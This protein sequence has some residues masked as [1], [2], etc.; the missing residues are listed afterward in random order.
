MYFLYKPVQT[1]FGLRL[2]TPNLVPRTVRLGL[3][4]RNGL[5][6]GKCSKP[7]DV[8]MIQEYIVSFISEDAAK[9]ML[10]EVGDDNQFIIRRHKKSYKVSEE[11]AKHYLK[12][13]GN[14]LTK[15]Q[16]RTS[17][18]YEVGDL[19][20]L[21]AD[22]AKRIDLLERLLLRLSYYILRGEEIPEEI[23]HSYLPLI[24]QYIQDVDSGEI[25]TR[26]DIEDI[27]EIFSKLKD[28]MSKIT[29]IVEKDYL[30]KKDKDLDVALPVPKTIV[31][32]P[33]QKQD[34]EENTEESK[35]SRIKQQKE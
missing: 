22:Q 19:Y 2:P 21:F 31:A 13:L 10:V 20:D 25:R 5:Y 28:K 1:Q 6:L 4:E 23:K 15:L 33:V 32:N 8:V 24:E 14:F 29:E 9:G 7:E 12:Q 30:S 17:I 11:E 27:D 16:V 18:G 26:I 34:K 35:W 3:A